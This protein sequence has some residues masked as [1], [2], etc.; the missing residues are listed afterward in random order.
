MLPPATRWRQSLTRINLQSHQPERPLHPAFRRASALL[1]LT[2]HVA[3]CQVWRV[4]GPTPG[5]YLQQHTPDQVLLKRAGHPDVLLLDPR[6][7]GDSLTGFA[8]TGGK[9]SFALADV[10]SL[11][12]RRISWGRTL[13][14]A[15]AVAAGVAVAAL[16][17]DCSD[18]RS[19]C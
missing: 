18:P 7:A 5:A 11:Q 14:L 17:S 9:P 16:L 10:Q 12:V 8:A 6:L 3:G 19:Y 13:G 15:G 1:L 2:V 4:A